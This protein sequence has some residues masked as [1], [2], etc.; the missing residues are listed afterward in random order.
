MADL[1]PA[2]DK[3][4]PISSLMLDD[5]QQQQQQQ[6]ATQG[7]FNNPQQSQASSGENENKRASV[8]QPMPQ[9]SENQGEARREAPA[10]PG[11]G[12]VSFGA[13]PQGGSNQNQGNEG[14]A[15]MSQVEGATP[16]QASAGYAQSAEAGSAQYSSGAS[17]QSGSMSRGENSGDDIAVSQRIEANNQLL[18]A[19]DGL[20]PFSFHNYNI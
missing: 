18:A 11:G 20:Y 12:W 19:K 9:S 16:G 15:Q 3:V 5:E 8:L 10:A 1:V 17:S 6:Q 7:S 14:T 4:I 13:Q 2:P